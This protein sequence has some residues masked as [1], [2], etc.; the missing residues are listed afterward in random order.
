MFSQV[1]VYTQ[2]NTIIEDLVL[3]AVSRLYLWLYNGFSMD[4]ESTVVGFY[5]LDFHGNKIIYKN[6]L[7]FF[8]R[9][10]VC[11]EGL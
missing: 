8:L 10:F 5:V 1:Y 3:S 11:G 7:S 9:V 4:N 6:E 2:T